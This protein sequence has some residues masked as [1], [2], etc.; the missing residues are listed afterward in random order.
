M[1]LFDRGLIVVTDECIK[2]DGADWPKMTWILA[3][4]FIITSLSLTVIAAEKSAGSSIFDRLGVSE[5][6]PAGT[7]DLPNVDDLLPPTLGDS[8]PLVPSAD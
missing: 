6:A 1:P 2:D 5:L 3:I 8:A 7:P 4:G